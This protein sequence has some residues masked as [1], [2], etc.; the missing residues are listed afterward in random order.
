MVLADHGVT[1]K[2][3]YARHGIANDGRT[4]VA[5]VHL[6]GQVRS[7]QVDHHLLLRASLGNAQLGIGQCGVQASS[8]GLGV[9]EEVQKAR[10]GDLDL[11]HLLVGRQRGDDFLCQV[12]GLHAGRLGQHHGDVAGEVAVG[13]VPGVFHLDRRRQ[14]FRQHTVGDELGEG[15]LD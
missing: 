3:Q 12:T 11:A 13:L 1:E 4:Q 9:L 10:A 15:L 7:R 14:P 8:Q 5:N 2:L 6:F